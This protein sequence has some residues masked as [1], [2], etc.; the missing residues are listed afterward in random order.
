MAGNKS[1]ENTT[2][3]TTVTTEHATH[4]SGV[5]IPFMYCIPCTKI[6]SKSNPHGNV[7]FEFSNFVHCGSADF[8]GKHQP[9][10]LSIRTSYNLSADIQVLTTNC[11][12]IAFRD[13]YGD[14]HTDYFHKRTKQGTVFEWNEFIQ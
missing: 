13:S 2:H 4:H 1:S 5:P 10:I 9:T 11:V 6:K 3:D 8:S 12:W 7:E 14:R